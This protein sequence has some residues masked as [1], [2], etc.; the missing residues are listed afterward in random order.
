MKYQNAHHILPQA[1]VAE[2]QQYIQGETL[3]IPKEEATHKKWGTKSGSRSLLDA[4]NQRIK[5][6]F[7]D[8]V[9]IAQLAVR[10]HLSQASIQKIVYG[11]KKADVAR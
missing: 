7:A 8:G 11:K 4:R 2:I 10:Y 1:L 6:S 9:S 5:R 3:Y